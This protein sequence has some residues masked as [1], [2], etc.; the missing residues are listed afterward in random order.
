MLKLMLTG[1]WNRV[2]GFDVVFF[3]IIDVDRVELEVFFL[4]FVAYFIIYYY[5]LLYYW[6][7]RQFYYKLDRL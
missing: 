2:F 4:I 7:D 1:I 3:F 5:I 6:R